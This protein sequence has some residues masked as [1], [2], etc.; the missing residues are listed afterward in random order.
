MSLGKIY[1]KDDRRHLKKVNGRYVPKKGC[2]WVKRGS[3]GTVLACVESASYRHRK[4]R[5]GKRKQPCRWYSMS[6]KIPKSKVCKTIRGRR[7]C[8]TPSSLSPRKRG[9]FRKVS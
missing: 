9:G 6:A 3:K 5:K 2:R 4:S 8:C 1:K 7:L